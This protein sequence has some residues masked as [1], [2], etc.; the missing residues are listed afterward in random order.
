MKKNVPKNFNSFV[1]CPHSNVVSNVATRAISSQVNINIGVFTTLKPDSGL[2]PFES[3]PPVVVSARVAM[4]RGP[5]VVNGDDNNAADSDEP[6][7]E[8][9]VDGAVGGG[10]SEAAA[11]EEDEN[12]DDV[13]GAERLGQVDGAVAG[14]VEG[15]GEVDAGEEAGGGVDV[16]EGEDAVDG[17][18]VGGD[19]AVEKLGEVAVEGAVGAAEEGVGE[20]EVGDEDPCV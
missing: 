1:G 13:G 12:G 19:F 17:E 20:L 6:S 2:D 7:A 18:R 15:S 8:S 14:G 5:P 11:V 16:V 10:V 4:L 3:V 9:V